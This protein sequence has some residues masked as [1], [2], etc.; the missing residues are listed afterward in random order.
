MLALEGDFDNSGGI[1]GVWVP[2]AAAG[3][4]SPQSIQ[5]DRPDGPIERLLLF[6]EVTMAAMAGKSVHRSSIRSPLCI[7]DCECGAVERGR[8]PER[9]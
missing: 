5:D 2:F 6:S 3:S 4:R 9:R 7:T 8:G 1:S